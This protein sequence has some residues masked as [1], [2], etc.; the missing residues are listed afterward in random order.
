L[1]VDENIHDAQEE[2]TVTILFPQGGVDLFVET[3][4]YGCSQ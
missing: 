1:G 3:Q 2:L 4:Y